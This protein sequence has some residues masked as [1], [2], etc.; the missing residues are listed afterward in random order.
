MVC[1]TTSKDAKLTVLME[2][3][4]HHMDDEEQE[5]LPESRDVI[6]DAERESLGEQMWERKQTL[7]KEFKAA[8]SSAA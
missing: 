3:L 5:M 1:L 6:D 4:R 2:N 8:A 7:T